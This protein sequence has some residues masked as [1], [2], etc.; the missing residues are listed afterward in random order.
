MPKTA[1]KQESSSDAEARKMQAEIKQPI[2]PEN[3]KRLE[4]AR[5]K[6]KET[7]GKVEMA[8]MGLPR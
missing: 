4:A 7:L 5:Q 2:D 8:M 3:L 1:T 6:I